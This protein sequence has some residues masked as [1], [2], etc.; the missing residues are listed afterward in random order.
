MKRFLL[1]ALVGIAAW[2]EAG[3]AQFDLGRQL[4]NI[5]NQV[6]GVLN[7]VNQYT[8]A[9]DEFIH[10]DCAAQGMAAEASATP[11]GASA[12]V[13]SSL[14]ALGAFQ[15]AYRDLADVPNLFGNI[16]PATDWRAVLAA[17]DTVREA[18]IWAAYAGQPEAAALAVDAFAARREVADRQTVLSHARR[19][20]AGELT[21]ALEAAEA[22]VD[23]LEARSP[24]TA[25][26]LGQTRAALTLARGELLA[27]LARHKAH[28]TA[29]EAAAVAAE[30]VARRELEAEHQRT[31]AA[32]AA[33]WAADRA[34]LEASRPERLE[35]LYGGFR[36][37]PFFGGE[38]N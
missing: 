20:A 14:N 4:T 8:A 1:L 26:A 32:L 2:P 27:A 5:A 35:A 3:R 33:E 10:L 11:A 25:T 28:E 30:E 21:A 34:A 17:A 23:A 31:R 15:G 38:N 18:D 6:T 9:V 29:L 12:V 13:C 37:H 19:D 36:L 24:V 22:A 16:L 7:Q